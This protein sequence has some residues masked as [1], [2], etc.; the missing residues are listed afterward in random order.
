[1]VPWHVTIGLDNYDGGATV[2]VMKPKNNRGLIVKFAKECI[3]IGPHVLSALT[4]QPLSAFSG[5]P[6]FSEVEK[7]TTFSSG[8]API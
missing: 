5:A 1:M 7:P 6:Q 8:C 2:Q 3:F 4:S